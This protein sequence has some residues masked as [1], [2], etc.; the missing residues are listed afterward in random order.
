M[1]LG[2]QFFGF[3]Q[4]GVYMVVS[5]LLTSSTLWGFQYLHHSSRI[6][7][8]ILSR[9]LEKELNVLDF[10]MD[11]YSLTVFPKTFLNQF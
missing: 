3:N 1:N 8:R 6:W 2:Y 5:M 10:P 7:L 4:C 9:A 11:P